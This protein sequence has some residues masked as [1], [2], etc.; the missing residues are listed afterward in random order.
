MAIKLGEILDLVG[1]LDDSPGDDT[2]GERFRKFL[3]DNIVE[4]GTIRDYIEES[5]ANSGDQYNRAFQDLVNHLG[6]IMEFEVEYGRYQGV[7]GKIGFD[8]LWKSSTKFDIVVEVKKS[9]VYTIET[10]P[11]LG[12]INELISERK[13]ANR[14]QA[15]GLY[16]IGRVQESKTFQLERNIITQKLTSQLKIISIESLLSLAELMS[17]YDVSHKDVL[18][19]IKP[20]GPTIDYI[21]DIIRRIAAGKPPFEIE[22]PVM[23]KAGAVPLEE[24]QY[25]ISPVADD[26]ERTAEETIRILVG[27]EKKYAIG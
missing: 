22:K 18:T 10:T 13:I 24:I 14:D 16:I 1:K 15:L 11:L 9:E 12:Y 3:K 4:L 6:T 17:E 5:L 2:P 23:S 20:S 7:S 21:A 27:E 26:R 8:G 25:W 19:V